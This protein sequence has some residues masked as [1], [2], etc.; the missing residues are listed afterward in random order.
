MEDEV[1]FVSFRFP[2]KGVRRVWGERESVLDWTLFV[3]WDL[4]KWGLTRDW[5]LS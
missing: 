1:S 5:M 2:P 4:E 3:R